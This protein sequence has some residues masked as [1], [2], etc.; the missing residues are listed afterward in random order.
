LKDPVVIF[1]L[2][3][4]L[5]ILQRLQRGFSLKYL[6]LLIFCAGG[7]AAFR[8]YILLALAPAA[9]AGFIIDSRKSLRQVVARVVALLILGL[10]LSYFGFLGSIE[11]KFGI[12][13]FYTIERLSNNRKWL[14][15]A[16]ES[17]YG[18]DVD[19][20]TFSGMMSTLPLGFTYLMLAPFPWDVENVR[21]AVTIPEVIVWWVMIPLLGYGIWYTLRH[22]PRD[23]ISILLFLLILTFTYSISQGGTAYRQRSQVQVFYLIFVAVSLVVIKEKRDDVKSAMRRNVLA[24]QTRYG[25][26]PNTVDSH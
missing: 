15:T 26:R 3:A 25:R 21:Q 22:R 23:A 8:F 4:A 9:V 2:V 24:L 5:C 16:A 1:F 19:V 13:G 7:I 17:G 11:S 20:S 14:A 12:G 18:K 10:G 6:S